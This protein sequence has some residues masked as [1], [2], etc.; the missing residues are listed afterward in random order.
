MRRLY[1]ASFNKEYGLNSIL[2]TKKK[3]RNKDIN[4][5]NMDGYMKMQEEISKN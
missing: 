5:K 1:I 3:G 4:V 2:K